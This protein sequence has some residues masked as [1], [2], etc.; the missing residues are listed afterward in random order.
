MTVAEATP[1]LHDP[2]DTSF[3]GHPKGLG[4]LAFTEAWER[5]SFYGMQAL[6][7]LYMVNSLLLPGEVE[8]VAGIE[9][10][11]ALYGGLEGQAFAS[12]IFGTYAASVYL[13]PIFGGLLADRVLGKRRTVLLGALTMAV[14]HFLMAFN[15]TFLLALLCLIVGSGMFKGNI[16]SQV[17]S[18][19]KPDDLRRADAFQI[20]YL[21]INAGVIASPLVVGT[22]GETMGWHWGFG[23]AGVGMV[24][25][26]II[27]IAGQKYL[28]REH[29]AP[30]AEKAKADP[31]PP[32]TRTDWLATIALLILIPVLAL[33]IVPNNQIFNA[34]LVWGDQQFAL[35]W[36]DEKLPTTWL[37]TLDAVVSVSFLAGV[38]AFY[39]WWKT[40]WQEPDELTK[41]II[42]SLFSM[43]GMA[44]LW[45]AAATTPEG[46][47]IG[48]F[49][50]VMFHIVNSIGFAHVLPVSLA[51]FAR[52][53]PQQ[54]SG[55]VIGLYFLAFFMGNSIVGWVG[56][57]FE[58]MPV[59][60]FWLMHMGFAAAAGVVF[61]LF[62][63]VLAPVL[64][65]K[66]EPEA[67]ATA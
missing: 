37:I 12:A 30:P 46:E 16:S 38:A 40:K 59:T 5:F 21:G 26:C 28:P 49:W 1:E 36:G 10:L 18:L 23:A 2:Q 9:Q 67:E 32:M 4:Y 24:I 61:L 35:Y 47:K 13:T 20:F 44:C 19:Y 7:V 25:G 66:A 3:L 55:T 50:P 62:K 22:L 65:G 58:T 51:L 41:I 57:W 17:G 56:G 53:A 33:A 39:R 43:G 63:L 6:L 60:Q 54:V 8:Q 64:M 29:F 27:Y 52:L 15:V 11:R 48:L 31:K 14:G 42:G 34:Y 45:M